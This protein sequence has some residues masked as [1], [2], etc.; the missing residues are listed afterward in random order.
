MLLVFAGLGESSPGARPFLSLSS[1]VCLCDIRLF[2]SRITFFPLFSELPSLSLLFFL[3][4]RLV[5]GDF[6]VVFFF[7]LVC[8]GLAHLHSQSPPLAHR[9]LKIENV[10]CTRRSSS[11][12]SSS[13][14]A[15]TRRQLR[16]SDL[17]EGEKE[18]EEKQLSSCSASSSSSACVSRSAPDRQVPSLVSESRREPAEEEE[19]ENSGDAD[20]FRGDR[21]R[22]KLEEGKAAEAKKEGRECSSSSSFTPARTPLDY[23]FKICDF[24]SCRAGCLDTSQCTREEILRAEDE[25]NRHTTLMYRYREQELHV[26]VALSFSFF[27]LSLT[28]FLSPSVYAHALCSCLH[29]EFST[30]RACA[31]FVLRTRVLFLS[32][33]ASS[34]SSLLFF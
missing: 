3:F 26:R 9:D 13:G 15:I 1:S 31:W 32:V 23:S 33:L 4:R 10:L 14:P 6:V 16:E 17:V 21:N 34:T 18:R 24:G 5:V 12:S 28:L 20:A 22:T 2:L 11:S 27:S 7:S 8:R 19:E 29:A 30:L 25:I